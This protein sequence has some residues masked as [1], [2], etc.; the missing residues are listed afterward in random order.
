MDMHLKCLVQTSNKV[1]LY[2]FVNCITVHKTKGLS[3]DLEP[4]CPKLAVVNFLGVLFFK[5]DHN[6]LRIQ[7]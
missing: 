1:Q 3:H 4:G 7:I 2:M 5:G 6:T